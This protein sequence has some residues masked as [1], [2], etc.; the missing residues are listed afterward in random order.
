MDC[1]EQVLVYPEAPI[2]SLAQIGSY[3]FR[4]LT[5]PF[6]VTPASWQSLTH[7]SDSARPAD[8]FVQAGL[9]CTICQAP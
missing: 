3:Q 9:P 6:S 4:S 7:H 1:F 5:D 2:D 8:H